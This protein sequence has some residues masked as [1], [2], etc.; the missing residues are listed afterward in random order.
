MGDTKH[1][2]GWLQFS[3]NED[4]WP[5]WSEKFES[6][7]HT[8]KLRK[9]LVGD[10]NGTAEQKYD[11]WAYLIQCLDKRSVMMLKSQ[12]KG[13]G[14]AAW[15]ALAAHFSSTETP[16]VMTLLERFTSLVLKPDE[17]MVDYLIRA[18]ELSTSLEQAGEKVSENLVISVV[19]K[20]L[21]SSYEYFKTVHDFSK[22]KSSFQDVKKALKNFDA[23]KN[24]RK[25]TTD[26]FALMAHA[27][28]SNFSKQPFTGKC[29]KCGKPGHQKSQCRNLVCDFC[30]KP[31]HTVDRCFKKN[32]MPGAGQN[33]SNSVYFAEES[34]YPLEFS[35]SCVTGV[36]T[37][38]HLDT[39]TVASYVSCEANN[40][41]EFL[42]D[43]GCTSHM[44]NDRNLFT[45]FTSDVTKHCTSANSS[46]SVIEG[47]GTVVLSL[48]DALGVVRKVK[49]DNCFYLPCHSRNLI[50]I[51]KL[52]EKGAQVFFGNPYTIRCKNGVS[53]PFEQRNGLYIINSLCNTESNFNVDV[54][55]GSNSILWHKRMGHNNLSDLVQLQNCVI[56]MKM[57][58]S[59]GKCHCDVCA[60]A[61]AHKQPVNKEKQPR[62]Q[63][64]L[65]LVYTDV[66]GPMETPSPS[67]NRFAISFTDSYSR[68]SRV[69]FMKNKSESLSKFQQSPKVRQWRGICFKGF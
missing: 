3:G 18:E 1:K 64:S 2:L 10:E 17:E 51:S 5:F 41:T 14:P 40:F 21:P 15:K 63:T 44:F 16:R 32:G 45:D 8:N 49:L 59:S 57:L 6:Y 68:Y 50:S 53:F 25:E 39:N 52:E 12:C 46:V 67:G 29:F 54:D 33:D 69:Y 61:K 28:S 13:D 30:N 60:L 11:I 22:D 58:S 35:L 37:R 7:I 4:D 26:N 65:E 27:S 48:R 43:S 20:G 55:D 47:T 42:L 38:A 34:S 66:A 19:L 9:Y 23:S 31:G 56:G 36:N 62:K 24:V